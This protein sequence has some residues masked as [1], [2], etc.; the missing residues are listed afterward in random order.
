MKDKYD[1]LLKT[2]QDN[3]NRQ[4]KKRIEK[5]ENSASNDYD[6]SKIKSDISSLEA[7][8]KALEDAS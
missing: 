8:I 5:L 6:D 3:I 4:F 2:D 1:P 7:R